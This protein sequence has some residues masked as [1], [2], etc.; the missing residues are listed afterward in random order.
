MP[1]DFKIP[2]KRHDPEKYDKETIMNILSI[3][4][5]NLKD[6]SKVKLAF[7]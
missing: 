1:A 7:R 3:S 6:F 4:E 5:E 2:K